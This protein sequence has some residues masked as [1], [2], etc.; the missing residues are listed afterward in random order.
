M[1]QY[2]SLGLPYIY[3]NSIL[4][5]VTVTVSSWHKHCKRVVLSLG[6]SPVLGLMRVT[7]IYSHERIH[8]VVFR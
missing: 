1:M 2:A 6:L 7:G 8:I 3:V 5:A 4:S